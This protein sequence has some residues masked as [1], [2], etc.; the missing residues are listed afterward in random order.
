MLMI[1]KGDHFF[2]FLLILASIS[3]QMIHLT[4][5]IFQKSEFTHGKCI[6]ITLNKLSFS[7]YT[8]VILVN[9]DILF[10]ISIIE[11]LRT[12]HSK[13]VAAIRL[14]P[15][16]GHLLLSCSMD[17]KIK[18]CFSCLLKFCKF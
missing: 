13:G 18:V 14:F 4:N 5:V 12:G 9:Y 6:I 16:S 3:H 10:L 2:T 1:T 17:T 11:L 15:K 8:V 7:I